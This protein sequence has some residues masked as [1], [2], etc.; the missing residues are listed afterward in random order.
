MI[1]SDERQGQLKPMIIGH[2]GLTGTSIHENSAAAIEA[3]ARFG[4]DGV[5]LDVQLTKDDVPIIW[6]DECIGQDTV[7][8]MTLEDCQK[9]AEYPLLTLKQALQLIIHLGLFF[10]CELKV[11]RG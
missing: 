10:M 2:R 4:F 8:Q 11:Y 3:C 7:S 5:E 6:H 9:T 1:K